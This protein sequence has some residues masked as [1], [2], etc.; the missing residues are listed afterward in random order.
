MF[1]LPAG[2]SL[3]GFVGVL[4]AVPVAAVV[5]VIMRHLLERYRESALYRGST[6]R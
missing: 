5:G 6:A 2:G 1:A 3:F 4:V